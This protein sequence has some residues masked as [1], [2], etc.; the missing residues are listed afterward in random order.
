MEAAVLHEPGPLSVEEVLVDDV[1][2]REVRV[3]TMATALCHTDLHFVEG[4]NAHPTPVVLGHEAAGIV[5]D[6]GR[7]VT[8]VEPRDR[9][10]TFPAGFCG[11]CE[12]CLRGRPTLCDL[13]WALGR[14]AGEP[15]R[16]RLSDGTSALQFA[17]LATFAEEMLVHENML[18]K[19]PAN[20]P[21][22]SAAVASC[23]VTTGLGA[24]LR[25]AKVEPGANVAVIG[26]GGTGL[27]A[28]QGALIAGAER[29][30]AIDLNDGKL[31][32]AR[33]FGATDTINSQS[34][35]ACAR[36]AELLPLKGGVDHAFEAVGLSETAQLAFR[37]TRRAGAVTL[38]GLPADGAT[39]E[40]PA[41]EFLV[42]KRVQ[43]T[44]MGSVW[45]RED[46]PF[47]MRLYLQGRLLL[48]E[49]VSATI[50]LEEINEGFVRIGDGDVAR[51]VVV[52]D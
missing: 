1:G 4:D 26:C 44:T 22:S 7:D 31:E 8:Y 5:E 6:T 27:N 38:I 21:F 16:L 33:R 30:I 48:D 3:R 14:G 37:V 18:V 2:P 20:V 11:R 34:S 51:T 23:A 49:L 28:I 24:V 42:E 13:G 12:F 40:F 17:N 46:I 50:P 39:V 47:F 36:V 29:I 25:C 45:F 35:D 10:I 19:I 41:V 32:L 52:F 15:P 9:V 43:G